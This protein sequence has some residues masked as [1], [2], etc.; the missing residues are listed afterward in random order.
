[1]FNVKM[2]NIKFKI[3]KAVN[4]NAGEKSEQSQINV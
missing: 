1:M 4:T 3:M 2:K